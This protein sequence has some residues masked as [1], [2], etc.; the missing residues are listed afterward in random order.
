MKFLI[1]LGNPG[2]KYLNTRHNFGF[3]TLDYFKKTNENFSSWRKNEKIKAETSEGEINGEK[4]LLVKPQTQMNASG[5]TVK[6]LFKHYQTKLD[7]FLI[8]HDDLDL[9]LGTIRLSYKISSG[10]HKGILSIIKNLNSQNFARLRLGIKTSEPAKKCFSFF[11]PR[12]S[13]EK[14]VLQ[15]FSDQ[16]MPLVAE[17]LEK[18]QKAI[19]VFLQEGLTKAQNLFN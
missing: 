19:L 17:C 10:G 3:M 1:G 9:P 2:L 13:A 6:L 14:F 5:E 16:E 18:S 7:D 4:I 8:I 15:K 12:L 11:F